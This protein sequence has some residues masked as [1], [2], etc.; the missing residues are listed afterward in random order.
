MKPDSHILVSGVNW[1]GDACMT[2]P[3]LQHLQATCPKIQIT[4]VAKP[5]LIPLWNMHPAVHDTIPLESS[6]GGM[7]QTAADVRRRKIRNAYVFP[8][9][10]RS[11]LPGFLAGVPHRTGYAGHHRCILINDYVKPSARAAQ[12]HQQ[13]EY[14]DILQL[15][16]V[17]ELPPP[18]LP[19]APEAVAA[20]SH[21]LPASDS[22]TW[23]GIL[24][25]AA[26][27]PSKRW[28]S[29]SFSTAATHIASHLE[30]KAVVLGVASEAPLCDEV[31]GAIG[32]SAISL[33]GKTSLTELAA[34]LS[35]CSVVLCNDSGGMHLA[36][37]VGT[38]VVAIYGITDPAKTGPLGHGHRLISAQGVE[39]SRDVPRDSGLAR[40]AL[41]SINPTQV[42]EAALDIL[43][44]C[45]S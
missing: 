23:I 20:I 21:A 16:E 35:K 28:P 18:S 30:A 42:A 15:P 43:R 12:G 41:L 10:W 38:P 34:A 33:A 5:G 31:A 37:A 27:G 24:P 4:M 39:A 13:W 9:S 26:R 19:V 1:L 25:G 40:E 29:K 2:M 22:T 3:A 44:D 11:A 7:L 45:R 14:V 36:A 32:S 8:N 6:L 17:E